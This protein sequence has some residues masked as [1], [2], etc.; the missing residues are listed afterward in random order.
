MSTFF[1]S[2][3][4]R[5]L[6]RMFWGLWTDYCRNVAGIYLYDRC[7]RYEPLGFQLRG[8]R[9]MFLESAREKTENMV[10]KIENWS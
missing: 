7:W 1:K 3:M 8:W 5:K 9:W 2:A 6:R 10:E 4:E